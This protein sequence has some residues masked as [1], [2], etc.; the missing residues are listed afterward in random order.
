MGIGNSF[1]KKSGP[2]AN[3]NPLGAINSS[4]TAEAA[5]TVADPEAGRRFADAVKKVADAVK[6]EMERRAMAGTSALGGGLAS[7]AGGYYVPSAS[8][9]W[10]PP[11]PPQADRTTL[12]FTRVS[13]NEIQIVAYLPDKSIK[14]QRFKLNTN[15]APAPEVAASKEK[16]QAQR[17]S[18]DALWDFIEDRGLMSEAVAWCD[19]RGVSI[20]N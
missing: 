2:H 9:H 18:L 3:A 5:R 16:L 20:S 11:E 19:E 1:K 17:E 13:L 4:T 10:P 12:E 14:A 15:D 7:G 6:K 8:S